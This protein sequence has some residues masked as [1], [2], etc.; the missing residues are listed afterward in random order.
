MSLDSAQSQTPPVTYH[1]GDRWDQRTDPDSV[2]PET[3]WTHG[4]RITVGS[5]PIR[6]DEV[7]LHHSSE[8]LLLRQ[9]SM[10]TTVYSLDELTNET[11]HAIKHALPDDDRSEP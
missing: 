11:Y 7:R 8:T 2:A 5:Q 4:Q 3:A 1:A 6:A 9:A 10:I